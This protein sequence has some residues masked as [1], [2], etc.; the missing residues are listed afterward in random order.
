MFLDYES[1]CQKVENLD[2]QYWTNSRDSR[3]SYMSHVIDLLKLVKAERIMEAGANEM[4]LNSESYLLDYPK[5]DLNIMDTYDFG[6][7]FDAFVAL[8]VWEHLTD[9]RRAFEGIM[10]IANI[11]ILSFPYKWKS[12]TNIHKNIDDKK[13]GEWTLGIEPIH[14]KDIKSNGLTRRICLWNFEK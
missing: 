14:T 10:K 3:W 6:I 5:Y 4:P 11:V 9:Q 2:K 1:Y 7:K 8:Q 12:G 13:I